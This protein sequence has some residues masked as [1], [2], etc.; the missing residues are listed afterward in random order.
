MQVKD[1][2]SGDRSEC[3]INAVVEVLGDQW[4]LLILRDMILLL[5]A[6][7]SDFLRADE[8]VATNIL[9]A[10]L[11]HL[12]EYGLIEKHKD[13][14]DGRA[15]LYVPT[16]QALD[17]IPVM[18]A[19]M[20]WSDAHRSGTKRYELALNAYR[21]DPKGAADMLAERARHHRKEILP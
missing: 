12:A 14:K 1:I 6:R 20:A 5:E 9:S 18:L 16:E 8:G 11:A 15:A 2:S 21:A 7:F 19:A 4:S 3:P 17:L 10:R 13:P